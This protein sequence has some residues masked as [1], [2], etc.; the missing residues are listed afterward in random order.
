MD[1]VTKDTPIILKTNESIKILRIVEIN[2]EEACYQDEN[3]I[4]QWG[5]EEFGVCEG[6]QVWTSE[7]WKNILRFV[8]HK[9]EKPI[10]R[11]GTKHGNVD[12]TEDHNLLDKNREIIKPCDLKL[13]EEL[14][15]KH[16]KFGE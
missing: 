3:V 16:L 7:G 11:I 13:G 10:Y 2:N 14:L 9:T 4:T 5:Y 6:L 8:T 12:L 15:P 1:S